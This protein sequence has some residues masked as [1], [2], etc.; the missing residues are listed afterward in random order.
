MRVSVILLVAVVFAAPVARAGD[1]PIGQT[2]TLAPG[3]LVSVGD[4]PLLVQFDEVLMDSRCPTGVVCFWEGEATIQLTLGTLGGDERVVVLH[5]AG[6]PLGPN[7]VEFSQH[8]VRLEQVQPYPDISAPIDPQDYRVDLV[9]AHAGI[10]TLVSAIEQGKS[11]IVM[12]RFTIRK[13]A[14]FINRS[15]TCRSINRDSR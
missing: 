5:T 7:G 6:S 12:P 1:V 2:F 3:E 14:K 11:I 9:V 13:P 8:V 15:N 10:S 4:L